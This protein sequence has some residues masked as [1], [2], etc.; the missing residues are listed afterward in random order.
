VL[1][2]FPSNDAFAVLARRR[3]RY[4]AIH[5]DMFGGRQHEIR[6]RLEAYAASLRLLSGDTRMSLYEVVRYP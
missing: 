1:D 3:V 2:S 5:W 4:I 6:R